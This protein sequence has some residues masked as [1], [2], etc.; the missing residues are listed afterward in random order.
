MIAKALLRK[1]RLRTNVIAVAVVGAL[2]PAP[3][4]AAEDWVWPVSGELITPYRNGADP[5]AAGQHRGIDVAA[6]VGT[7]VA[8]ATAGTVRFA[9]VAGSSGLTVSV[10]TADG[11]FDTSYLHLSRADVAEGHRVQRGERLGA[12]GTSGERSAAA[13]HLHFGVREAGSRHSYRNPLDLL[14]PPAAP[15]ARERPRA[16]VPVGAPVR[17]VPAPLRVRPPARRPRRV[18]RGVRGPAGERVPFP[19]AR[20]IPSPAARRI[21]VSPGVRVRVPVGLRAPLPRPGPLPT[22][23]PSPAGGPRPI[24]GPASAPASGGYRP[25]PA[26]AGAGPGAASGPDVGWALACVGLLLAAA[27]LGRPG[28]GGDRA[29]GRRWRV[30]ARLRP[31]RARAHARAPSHNSGTA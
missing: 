6:P 28:D 4:A 18:P 16:P 22:A 26:D 5:Y 24:A 30:G 27:C 11:R 31:A 29:G 15:P 1:A 20:R 2:V 17:V 7:P 19:A 10:R 8:A 13:P 9:G 14:P 23:G 21:P 12:V 25:S 3:A